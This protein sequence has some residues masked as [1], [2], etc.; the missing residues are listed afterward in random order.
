MDTG[1][2]HSRF[3]T[4]RWT[5]VL[6]AGTGGGESG[7]VLEELCKE[8]WHPLF[9]FARRNGNSDSDARDLTQ[10]FFVYLLR[11]ELFSAAD[12]ERGRLRSFLIKAFKRYIGAVQKHDSA[13]KRGGNEEIL[14]LDSEIAKDRLRQVPIASSTPESDYDKMWALATLQAAVRLL[15]AHEAEAGRDKEFRELEPFLMADPPEEAEYTKAEQLLGKKQPALR[16]SVYR[17]RKKLSR[18]LRKQIAGTLLNPSAAQLEEEMAAL[19]A[20]LRS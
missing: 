10:G 19:K 17:L 14:P 5:L 8:Y 7:S 1:R 2:K 6:S 15:A 3:P 16:T 9:H 20:A 18:L 13:A 11:R 4:T 12:P